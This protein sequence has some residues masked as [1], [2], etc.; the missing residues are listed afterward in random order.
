MIS[1]PVGIV[2]DISLNR[3]SFRSLAKPL[4]FVVVCRLVTPAITFVRGLHVE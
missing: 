4:V 3:E 1:P 2:P